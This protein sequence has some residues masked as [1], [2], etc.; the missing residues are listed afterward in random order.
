MHEMALSSA[1]AATVEKHAKGRPVR[2]VNLTVGKL[3]QVVPDS[4]SFYFDIVTRDTLMEGAQLEIEIVPARLRCTG[5]GERWEP[6][7][8]TFRCPACVTGVVEVLSGEEFQVESIEV[9]ED[10]VCTAPK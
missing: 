7:F 2:L 10:E 4:L 3:R 5:C 8:P 6:D 1:V 9:E